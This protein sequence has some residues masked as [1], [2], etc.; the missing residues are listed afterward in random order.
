MN[1]IFLIIELAGKVLSA[2]TDSKNNARLGVLVTVAVLA[3]IIGF[4]IARRKAATP[5]R[6]TAPKDPTL[7]AIGL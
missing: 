3:F 7:R 4:Y 5:N 2:I 6:E 1:N